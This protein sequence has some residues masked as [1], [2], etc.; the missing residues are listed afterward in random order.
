MSSSSVV[1]PIYSNNSLYNIS[2]FDRATQNMSNTTPSMLLGKEDSAPNFIFNT[3]WYSHY[4]NIDL[5]FNY[6]L[7]YQNFLNTKK[8]ILP[9]I[10][11]YSEYDFRN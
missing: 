8:V 4:K 11:E 2:N 10:P 1:N 7:V 6:N 9:T 5:F 3:Y